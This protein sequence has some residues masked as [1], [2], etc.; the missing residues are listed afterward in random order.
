[1]PKIETSVLLLGEYV[2]QRLIELAKLADESQYDVLWYADERFFREVYSGLTLA[3]VNTKRIHLGTCVTDPYSRHPALTAM[4]I[5]TLD[6]MSEGRAVLGVGAGVSGFGPLGVKREKPVVAIREMVEVISKLLT[7]AEVDYHGQLIHLSH[8]QLDFKPLRSRVPVYIASNGELGL[9]L[10]GQ[11]ADGAIMQ[12]AVAPRT[13]DW[14]LTNIARGA[15]KAGREL[16]AID[17]VAR[18]NVCI[19]EDSKAAKD[20][21][22]SGLARSLIA[23]QPEFPTFKVA[24]LEVTAEMRERVKALG[25]TYDPEKLAPVAQLIPDEYVDALTL[26][27]TVDEIAAGVLRLVH[28]GITHVEVFPI[29]LEGNVERV[30]SDFANRV[31]P[32][33]NRDLQSRDEE[34]KRG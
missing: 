30:I 29:A 12:G 14:M 3:A 2:P 32:V 8:G 31:M 24:R 9:A 7:G 26:A 18:I 16:S 1:M 20:K 34:S 25:Y 21:M 28:C 15:K 6:E 33:V 5:A 27:G 11:V 10:A 22:R 13:I 23:T 4:A 17:R 19:A